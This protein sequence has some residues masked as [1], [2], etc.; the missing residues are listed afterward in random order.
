MQNRLVNDFALMF[1]PLNNSLLKLKGVFSFWLLPN[2]TKSQAHF[3]FLYLEN[4]RGGQF[5]LYR[6]WD[7]V[8]FRGARK[9]KK[10]PVA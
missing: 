1:I 6:A 10:H 8:K 9:E 7:L 3:K 2:L 5:K 4:F